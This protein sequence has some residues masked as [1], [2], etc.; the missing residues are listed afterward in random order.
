MGFGGGFISPNRKLDPE[1][2]K[3]S[4]TRRLATTLIEAETTSFDLSDLQPPAF[5]A[6]SGQ[7]MW[8]IF[9]QYLRDGPA[10]VA[11]TMRRLQKGADAARTCER[12]VVG[13]R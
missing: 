12:F 10:S 5:G 9:E 3:D 13:K 8:R 2:Y 7:G 11:M 1:V 4:I 6:E